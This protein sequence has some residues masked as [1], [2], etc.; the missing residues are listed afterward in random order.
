MKMFDELN[1]EA[2]AILE[3]EKLVDVGKRD[4]DIVLCMQ[5]LLAEVL[6]VT[7]R[8]EE[9]ATQ[10]YTLKERL[11][12]DTSTPNAPYWLWKTTNSI[13][14]CAIRQRQWRTAI[15]E[16]LTLLDMIRVAKAAAGDDSKLMVARAEIVVICR[17]SRAMLQIGA[18][19][20]ALG[21]CQ[22]ANARL[23]ES[24]LAQ[25]A[26]AQH[27]EV[28]KGLFLFSQDKFDEALNIFANVISTE[29]ALLNG[30]ARADS[31]TRSCDTAVGNIP[32]PYFSAIELEE[33]LL[34]VAVCN[35]SVAALHLRRMTVS[36]QKLE[37]LIREDPVRYLIDPIVFNLC[38]LYELSCSP[39]VSTQK[40]KILQRIASMY[41]VSDPILNW[42]SLRLA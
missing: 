31:S 3:T 9:A 15:K 23:G 33:S 7:G 5:L 42:K 32:F 38:T 11:V 26:V 17:L 29:H 35:Y 6:S 36:V 4:L 27:V 16:L 28:S 40:K 22:Q 19:K 18:T 25:D 13:V 14:N 41:L 34:S 8:S 1:H 39:D 2:S 30:T 21:Y 10:L 12:V 24:L 37:S 20:G